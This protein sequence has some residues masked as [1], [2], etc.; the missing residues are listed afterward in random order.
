[1]DRTSDEFDGIGFECPQC[2]TAL[3]AYCENCPAC[4]CALG[5]QFSATYRPAASRAAKTVAFVV[6][7]FGVAIPLV[8]LLWYLLS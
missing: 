8:V 3:D 6:L 2:G 4:G 5:E 1:M 7:L